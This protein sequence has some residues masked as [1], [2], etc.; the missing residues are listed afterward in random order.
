MINYV[1]ILAAIPFVATLIGDLW[2]YS[3][4][5][6]LRFAGYL[7]VFAFENAIL[8][9]IL[10]VVAVFVIG[11]V[12]RML[13]P[14]FGTAADEIKSLKLAAYVFTPIFLIGALDIIPILGVLSILGVLYGLYILYIGLPIV[15]GTPKDK[16]IGYVVGVVIATFIVYF[17]ID[18]VVAAITGFGLL[19]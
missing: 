15:L 11:V 10:D 4:F 7:A 5:V 8:V 16:V 18:F 12:I 14:T 19:Y 6:S 9:Y 13:G 3:L 1:A 17:I 2:Y